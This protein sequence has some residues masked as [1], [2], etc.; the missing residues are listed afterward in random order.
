[1]TKKQRIAEL[2]RRIDQLETELANLRGQPML[3]YGRAPHGIEPM[4]IPDVEPWPSEPIHTGTP[5]PPRFSVCWPADVGA[6]RHAIGV[7]L[8]FP[9]VGEPD[10]TITSLI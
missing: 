9:S 4:S 6:V 10:G 7:T 8:G 3:V 2:E 5:L 1:M